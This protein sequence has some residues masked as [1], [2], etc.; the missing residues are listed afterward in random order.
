MLNKNSVYAALTLALAA[1]SASF[2]QDAADD[3]SPWSGDFSA[4]YLSSSGNTDDTTADFNFD[5]KY[6]PKPWG[7]QFKGRAY[8]TSSSNVTTAESYKLGWKS[9]YDFTEFN[10]AFGAVDWNKDRFAAYKQQTFAT[11][12]YGRRFLNSDTFVLNAEIG[13]GYAEQKPSDRPPSLPAPTEKNAVGTLG[14]DFLWNFS[15][16]AAFEQTL[17]VFSSSENTYLESVSKVT[18]G[19]VGNV[20]LV[21][22]YTIKKNT[23]L[24][25]GAAVGTDK[26]DT[27]TSLSLNYSF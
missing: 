22:S 17:Y 6:Q 7:H 4:G 10:Y 24:P 2:A 19:L 21:L 5:V 8:G 9:T 12:G 26:T 23:D 16:N 27:L 3:S 25:A 11:V 1:H 14:G 20:G 13:V 18:A 15:E